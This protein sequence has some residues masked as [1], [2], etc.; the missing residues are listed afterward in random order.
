MQGLVEGTSE[1]GVSLNRFVADRDGYH[2]G[3]DYAVRK[4]KKKNEDPLQVAVDQK[5]SCK[6]DALWPTETPRVCT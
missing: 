5:A 1:V 6:H 4:W 3:D 2:V